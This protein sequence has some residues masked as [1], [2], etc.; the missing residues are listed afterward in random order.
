MTAPA[1]RPRS[2]PRFGLRLETH[3][4]IAVTLVV[5]FALGAAIII[6]SRVVTTDSLERA[7]N[8]LQA[9]RSAFYRLQDDRAEFAAAQTTLVTS[10]PIFRAH[11]TDTPPRRRRGDAQVMADEYRLQLKAA[12]CIVTGRLSGRPDESSG[13]AGPA[14]PPPAVAT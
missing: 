7:A 1:A 2:W 11:L 13:M 14:P 5:A 3:V 12:F 6:T 4:A 10:L 8:D 9:A